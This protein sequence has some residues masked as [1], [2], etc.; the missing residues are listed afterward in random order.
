[1]PL[2]IKSLPQ[3]DAQEAERQERQDFTHGRGSPRY[4]ANIKRALFDEE[5][6]SDGDCQQP[7]AVEGPR[8]P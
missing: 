5:A 6:E 8:L 1:M 7:L 4:E 3:G 2:K